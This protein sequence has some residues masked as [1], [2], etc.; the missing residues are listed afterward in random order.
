MKRPK[1]SVIIPVY[2]A[3]TTIEKCLNSLLNQS[4]KDFEIIAINDG[5]K[6]NTLDVLNSWARIYSNIRVVNQENSGVAK[7]RNLGIKLAKSEYIMFVD[8]D[9]YF[10][11]DYVETFYN[12]IHRGD[13]DIVIGGYKRVDSQGKILH[14]EILRNTEWSKYIIVAPWARIYKKSF[15]LNN[16]IEFF[17]Y[18]I[19]EDV[20]FNIVAYSRTDKVKVISYVGYFWYFNEISVSNTSQRGLSKSLD[21]RVVIQEIRDKS[22]DFDRTRLEYYLY[23]YLAWYLLFS[24]KQASWEEFMI[25]FNRVKKYLDHENTYRDLLFSSVI[26]GESVKN[27]V[28][29]SVFYWLNRCKLLPI[30]SKIYCKS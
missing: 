13:L 8:N 11:E 21:L 9:D 4:M 5:S 1:V 27:R 23:R 19:G 26:Q 30:F 15:L 12:E 28:I 7:T 22:G 6:D 29:V 10:N 18:G 17:D 24:G 3:E 2:N 25:Q 16:A 14:T 20:V